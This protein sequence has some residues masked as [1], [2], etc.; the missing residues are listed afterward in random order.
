[1]LIIKGL[2]PMKALVI[3]GGG[4]KGAWAGGLVE[5]LSKE[6]GMEWDILIGSSTGSLLVPCVASKA[7]EEVKL[8]YT[9]SCQKDIFSNCPF[10]V[11]KKDDKFHASFNHISILIQFLQ[12]RK[13]LGESKSLRELIRRTFTRDLWKS[14]KASGKVIIVTVSNLTNNVIEYKYARDFGYEEFCDWIWIS[15]NMVPFM[16]LV[17]KNGCE[18]ADGGF[19]NPI[20]IQEAINIGATEIDVV[21]LQPRHRAIISPPASNAFILLLKAFNFMQH[22]LSRDDISVSLAESRNS[23]TRIRLIHTQEELTENSF[24]FDPEQMSNWWQMGREHGRKIYEEGFW[25]A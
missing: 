11:R 22:Q 25:K 23:G 12:Q 7:W 5:Y 4:S 24:I 20:P 13:T 3:S 10:V 8:A 18:Y 15:C 14:M 9:T 21:V 17:K 16:S 2:I 1:M 19:G 6:Q